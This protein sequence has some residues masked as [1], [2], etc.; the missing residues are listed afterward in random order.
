[1]QSAISQIIERPPAFEW[2]LTINTLTY[3]RPLLELLELPIK[4]NL[5][6]A[7]LLRLKL[8]TDVDQATQEITRIKSKVNEYNTGNYSLIYPQFMN[9]NENIF[10]GI[11]LI[12][13]QI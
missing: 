6:I 5:T 12:L 2:N 13:N 7:E 9:K 8:V 4:H 10:H 3:N 1:M 11:V